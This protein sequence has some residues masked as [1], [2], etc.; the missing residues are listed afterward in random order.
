MVQ[1]RALRFV[2]AV[3][4]LGV[5]VPALYLMVISTPDA[6]ADRPDVSMLFRMF[7]TL[8]AVRAEQSSQVATKQLSIGVPVQLSK[9][10]AGK[11][12]SL[13]QLYQQ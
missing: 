2:T 7:S 3:V 6:G 10:F 5:P 11:V 13:V 9:K 4:M 8:V 12:V 1:L